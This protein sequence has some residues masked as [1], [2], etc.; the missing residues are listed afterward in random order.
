MAAT[1]CVRGSRALARFTTVGHT[2][3]GTLTPQNAIIVSLATMATVLRV[4][5]A[6]S[7]RPPRK[8]ASR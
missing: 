4:P 6:R 7:T 3:R 2:S 5:G 8:V 1:P